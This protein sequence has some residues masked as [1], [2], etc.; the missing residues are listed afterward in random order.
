METALREKGTMSHFRFENDGKCLVNTGVVFGSLFIIITFL[1]AAF[2]NRA[3]KR[4]IL[5][6]VKM[7]AKRFRIE[8]VAIL[9]LIILATLGITLSIFPLGILCI[10][11]NSIHFIMVN[12]CIYNI[13]GT[14]TLAGEATIVMVL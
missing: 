4:W 2:D 9:G 11:M 12:S 14:P 10:L 3:V 1:T 8:R 6:L 7:N 5:H 13:G